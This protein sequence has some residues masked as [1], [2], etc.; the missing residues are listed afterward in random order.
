MPLPPRY[1]PSPR[2]SSLGEGFAD[3]V[4]PARFPARTLRFRNQRW[5]SRLGLGELDAEAWE[6]H[7]ARLEPLPDNLPAPLALRY[8]GHQFDVYN[9]HL[10]DG[11]G[12]LL[13]QLEDPEDGRLLDFGTKGSGTTPWS[14]GG[15]GRLTLKGGV[16]EVLAAEMLEALAVP[17][18]KAFSLFET[19]E[20]LFRGD[21]P[22][23]TRSSV[24]VRLSHGHIRF[25]T[26]QRHAYHRDAA[27]LSKLLDFCVTHYVPEAAGGA[28]P[29]VR[30]VEAVAR[31]SAR[32]VARWSAAGFVHGVLNSD[33]MNITGE[34]FDYGPY[35]FLPTLDPSFIAAYFDHTGLYAFGQQARAVAVNL[36]RLADALRLV[37]PQAAFAP[38]VR[39]FEPALREARSAAFLSRMG[40][41]PSDP[42]IDASLT[43]AIELFLEE[44]GAPFD[45]FFFDWYGGAASE[46]RARASEAAR[47]YQGE[48][49][50]ALRSLI[51]LYAPARPEALSHP[52][53]QGDGPCSLLIDE[54]ESIWHAIDAHDDWGPFEAKVAA[55]RRMGEAL[56]AEAPAG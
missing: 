14:R 8:H 44:S 29:A 21:E 1:R 47:F 18:S 55:I 39:A 34:S 19:H 46:A 51:D 26:F 9:P 56:G 52:Y 12:F 37:A 38:A 28:E 16:R 30:F 43:E 22:S 53:F 27:R 25:G 20:A 7:F 35:R 6:R 40:L 49:F 24:L 48:R 5:A 31:R 45:P 33:N 4:A 54:I 17:T 15:D 32:L 13:A 2:I 42:D 41:S 50:D 10:G 3:V 11:R 23:P 36:T